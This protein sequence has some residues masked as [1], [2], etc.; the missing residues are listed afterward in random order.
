MEAVIGK[1]GI[2]SPACP[3]LAFACILRTCNAAQDA[4]AGM[5]IICGECRCLSSA[6]R[7]MGPAQH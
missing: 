6:A 1:S 5:Q 4:L 3:T 7:R 2:V